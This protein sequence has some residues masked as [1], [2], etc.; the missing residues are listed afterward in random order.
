MVRLLIDCSC[1]AYKSLFTM[2]DLSNDEK[3]VGVIFGFVKQILTLSKKFETNKFVFCWDHRNSYRKIEYPEYKVK[4]HS[5]AQ[6]EEQQA[7][8][9]DAFRQF[10]EI[11]ELILPLM[12]FTNIYQQSG[13]EADDLI[14]YVATRRPDDTVIVSTDNDL[15]QLI[16]HDRFCPIKIYNFKGITDEAE[17]RRAWFNISPMKWSFVKAIAGCN[18]DEVVGIAG[19][20][21]LT[22]AKYVAGVLKGKN[23]EKINSSEG[24]YIFKRN[25]SLVALPYNGIKSINLPEHKDDDIAIEKFK[26]IFGQYGFKSLL[27]EEE[28]SKWSKSF[29]GGEDGKR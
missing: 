8:M 24:Q 14:A 29:F 11:R 12:G 25:L 21:E 19:V 10:D 22:A 26:A 1:L 28:I 6:T 20:G 4:R 3:R 16:Y 27:K 17:F 15:L 7:D 23:L 9:Q 2:G 13:Y 18:S 5:K